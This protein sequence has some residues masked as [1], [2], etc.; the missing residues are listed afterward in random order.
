VTRHLHRPYCLI[1]DFDGVIADSM[2][3]HEAAWQFSIAELGLDQ[4][5]EVARQVIDNLYLGRAGVD[6]FTAITLSD[7]FKRQL[8]KRKDMK[9][10]EYRERVRL[11][12][13]CRPTIHQLSNQNILAIASTANREYIQ[14]FL[15]RKR[16]TRQFK[17][18]VTDRDV[19]HGKPA[20]DMIF[21]I[22]NQLGFSLDQVIVVG[23][24]KADEAMA[25]A[26][27]VKFI[28]FGD[29]WRRSDKVTSWNELA[30]LLR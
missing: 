25:A 27:N 21:R 26:A 30:K 28:P 12:R 5:S 7:T 1:F 3:W 13:F 2:R 19:A 10:A 15:A 29:R 14:N 22:C 17:A 23:D 4:K 6:M 9:W 16:L 20:P 11:H 18:I 8:R 24:T